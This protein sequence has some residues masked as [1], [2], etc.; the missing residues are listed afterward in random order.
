MVS[1][2]SGTSRWLACLLD[3][4]SFVIVPTCDTP[5]F[6]DTIIYFP[7][8]NI[9][10]I[11][12]TGTMSLLNDFQGIRSRIFKENYSDKKQKIVN[13]KSKRRQ[14]FWK[15]KNIWNKCDI[16]SCM[17]VIMAF[18]RTQQV[19]HPQDTRPPSQRINGHPVGWPLHQSKMGT[20][21]DAPILWLVVL[22]RLYIIQPEKPFRLWNLPPCVGVSSYACEV[23]PRQNHGLCSLKGCPAHFI[24]YRGVKNIP[25]VEN[26]FGNTIALHRATAST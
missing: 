17:V 24:I 12:K 13:W 18:L 15:S 16:M 3:N 19:L 2:R 21:E 26:I 25:K 1:P 8:K 14:K 10:E 9:P 23:G 11:Q 4:S 22:D 7:S 6:Y 20:S 5:I